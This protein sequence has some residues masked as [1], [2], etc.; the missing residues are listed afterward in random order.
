MV[1]VPCPVSFPGYQF[2]SG[3]SFY[4][5]EEVGEGGYVYAE[6][7]IYQDVAL[8]DIASM[9]PS[10]IECLDLFGPYTA[11]FSAIK[12]A[13]LAIK[14][15]E[16]EKAATL[17]DG[18]LKAYLTDESRADE[19]AYA[20]KIAIN[21]VYG[22]TSAKFQNKFKDP[23]N[24]ENIVAKRG[25]LFM[26]ELKHA[27][28][29]K[30]FT[31]AHIKTDSIKIPNATPEI[32]SFVVEFGKKY[33][34]SFEHEATYY[35]MCLVNDA[36]YIARY[37]TADRCKYL[38]G[39]EYVDSS[40]DICKENKKKGG[41]WTATGAQFAQPYVFKTL[42]TKEPIKFSDLC[43][44]KS[45]TSYL[46]LDMN[47]GLPEVSLQEKELAKTEKEILNRS[48]LIPNDST[49]AELEELKNREQQLT[50]E[51]ANGHKYIFV[52]KVGLFTPI[53]QGCGGGLLCREHNG[54]FYSVTGTKGYR[55]LESEIVQK[56]DK[57]DDIDMSFY[58]DLARESI[59][60]ICQFG[61]LEEF[62]APEG[63]ICS[64]ELPCRDSTRG[65]CFDCPHFYQDSGGYLCERG[66]DL[67][68][69]I[70]NRTK[71]I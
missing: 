55:W 40:R 63:D 57:M 66:Y 35:K 67:K 31:V 42:F 34:Y 59:S 28:Q 71:N 9:H 44:T 46:Y 15:R 56:L 49:I 3:K 37:A 45:V 25:A 50:A 1:D 24:V 14:H 7:G 2:I 17:F 43:E 20:L 70:F 62:L 19:L 58:V 38:Y 5:G 12:E 10:S 53:R 27:V 48:K 32:I 8:L 33:G 54:K 41:T 13:R 68:G 36:V 64:Q 29:E 23:R 52:G 39:T 61:N 4:K 60:S 69:F 47:E 18:K 30:G 22:L 16:F 51:I 6:P 26:V 11:N 21:I 65:S